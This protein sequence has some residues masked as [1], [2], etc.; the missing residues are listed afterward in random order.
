MGCGVVSREDVQSYL[1]LGAD[2]VSFCTLALRNP[3]EAVK[4]I[5]EMN[6]ER[7]GGGN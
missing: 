5:G 6:R 4:V 1:D 7:V 3:G 2:A